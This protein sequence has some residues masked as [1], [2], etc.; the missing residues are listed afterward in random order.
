ERDAQLRRSENASLRTFLA[1]SQAAFGRAGA[2]VAPTGPAGGVLARHAAGIAR[3]AQRRPVGVA[4]RR[5]VALVPRWVAVARA[6]V[7][8]RCFRLAGDVRSFGGLRARDRWCLG[9][10]RG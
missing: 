10:A 3:R 6:V 8:G 4:A 5:V 7:A 9:H 2:L 1:G